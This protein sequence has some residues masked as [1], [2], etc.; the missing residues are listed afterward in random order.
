MPTGHSLNERVS[1]IEANVD[2]HDEEI[3]S[4][5]TSKHSMAN[6]VTAIGN[7]VAVMEIQIKAH[8]RLI[9][10]GIPALICALFGVASYF[11]VKYGIMP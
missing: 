2:A 6:I 10:L 3:A 9:W 4:L 11:I 5:R 7:R 1:K 8:D